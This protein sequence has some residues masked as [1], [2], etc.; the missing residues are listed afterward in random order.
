MGR[1]RGWTTSGASR[2]GSRARRRANACPT[3][4]ITLSGFSCPLPSTPQPYYRLPLTLSLPLVR[5]GPLRPLRLFLT[6]AVLFA[7]LT[8][9][10]AQT[11]SALGPKISD[12]SP[13][14]DNILLLPLNG[15]PATNRIDQLLLQSGLH[16][17]QQQLTC[18][19]NYTACEGTQF[20]CPDGNVC[21][22]GESFSV[23]DHSTF[24]GGV[25]CGTVNDSTPFTE[26]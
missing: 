25:G 13:V 12:A 21:C 8:E 9:T 11:S 26:C 24:G 3:S 14:R 7:A 16:R 15:Q 23:L 1:V 4:T 10:S 19:T 18:T 22:S 6:F 2:I 5:M 17:R 20:C